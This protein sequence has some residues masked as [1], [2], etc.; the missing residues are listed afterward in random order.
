MWHRAAVAA[1]FAASLFLACGG[2]TD[3]AGAGSS[4]GGSSSGGSSSGGP[5]CVDVDLTTYD[6][7]C[8]VDSDCVWITSGEVCPGYCDCAADA[9]INQDGLARY[10]QAVAGVPTSACHCS[11]RPFGPRCVDHQCSA[12][13]PD[14]GPPADAGACVNIDPS[15]YDRSCKVDADCT[16]I[17]SGQVCSGQCDC[18][19]DAPV[20]L[21]GE[22]Q[23]ESAVAGLLLQGCPC[24]APAQVG[25]FSG[26]CQAALASGRVVGGN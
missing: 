15:A 11:P 12:G 2:R 17:R 24:P 5:G 21:T 14:A 9:P 7:S 13:G 16:S 19:G 4:S 25:C 1:S 8:S 20:S 22:A 3:G 23:Y 6:T 26:T 10:Q 18:G